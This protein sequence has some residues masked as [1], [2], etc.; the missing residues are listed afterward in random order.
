M[1]APLPIAGLAILGV[2][3]AR[4]ARRLGPRGR[5]A[6]SVTCWRLASFWGGMLAVAVALLP[7]V[8]HLAE[9]SLAAHM[10][11]H[12]L[13]VAVGAP[14]MALG[15]PM[16]VLAMAGSPARAV[17]RRV[18]PLVRRLLARPVYVW[19]AHTAVLWLWHVPGFYLAALADPGLHALEHVTLLGSGVLFWLVVAEPGVSVRL[20]SMAAASYLFA[21][22]MQCGALGALLT[23]STTPWYP[24]A[25][26][27]ASDPLVDQQLAGVLM[28]VPATLVYLGA[29]LAVLARPLSVEDWTPG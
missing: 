19:L 7:P 4:G 16:V 25:A 5:R 12:L 10:V 28:W 14:L 27:A 21:A 8:D 2:L 22:A 17:V 23:L 18:A 26:M 9:I 20:G 6:R 13:L 1:I 11:Q 29:T 3:Y 15:R 24:Q